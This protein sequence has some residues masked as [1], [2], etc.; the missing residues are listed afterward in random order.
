MSTLLQKFLPPIPARLG[1]IV[2]LV[3]ALGLLSTCKPRAE[4]LVIGVALDKGYHAGLILALEEIN[5]AGGIGGIP[6]ETVGPDWRMLNEYDPRE[7]MIW[8]NS[9][10]E[11]EELV[12]VIGHSDS[13]STLASAAYYNQLQVP[14]IVTIATNR[15]ISG[16]GPWTYRLCP[17]DTLQ[18]RALAEYAVNDWGKQR[19]AVFFVDDDFGRGLAEIFQAEFRSLGGQV[20][21]MVPQHNLLQEEDKRLIRR[22]LT[23]LAERGF[24]EEGDLVVLLQRRWVAIEIITTMASLAITPSALGADPLG[25]PMMAA[26]AQAENIDLRASLFFHPGRGD[27]R[28]AEFVRTFKEN[29]GAEPDYGNAYAYD[30]VYLLRDAI[31]AGASSRPGVKEGLDS[32]IRDGTVINGVVG[33][34]VIGENNDARRSFMI[35]VA[36]DGVFRPIESP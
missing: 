13:A 21:T 19:A 30:A 28:T 4:R 3:V 24:S 6:V 10:A 29:F 11:S 27:P 9:F 33:S 2:L 36:S 26:H 34:Y 35:G 7:A 20:V 12:A 22:S 16:I 32:F 15:A 18:G 31:L 14:H 23:H 25:I 17:S 1:R 5:A 8:A